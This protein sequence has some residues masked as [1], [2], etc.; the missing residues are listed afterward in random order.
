MAVL[1][2]LVFWVA[3]KWGFSLIMRQV[4]VAAACSFAVIGTAMG[5]YN[6]RAYNDPFTMPY[7]LNRERYA[8]ISVFLWQPDK[9]APN[10]PDEVMRKFYLE[11]EPGVCKNCA[12]V[13]G[14]LGVTAG[15][16]R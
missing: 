9:P 5:Y 1:G 15:K 10:Y 7:Q 11:A 13:K 8:V 2:W 12:G 14:F 3:E 16:I 6:W 4:V